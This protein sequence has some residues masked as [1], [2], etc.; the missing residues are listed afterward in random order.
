MEKSWASRERSHGTAVPTSNSVVSTRLA[1]LF[2]NLI[3]NALTHGEAGTP[4]AVAAEARDGCFSFSVAN[5]GQPI[6]PH[7][8]E[9]LFEPFSR[10]EPGESQKG[11][12]LGLYI[13]WEIARA[14]GGR[15]EVKSTVEETRFTF[16]MPLG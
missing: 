10:G 12:G 3:G 11:L 6:P 2:S 15:L 5:Q 14:H 7:V 8:I 13:A 1:Q 9:K 4:V 16:R